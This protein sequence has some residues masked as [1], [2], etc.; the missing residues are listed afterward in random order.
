MPGEMHGSERFGL[1]VDS[2]GSVVGVEIERLRRNIRK[3]DAGAAIDRPCRRRRERQRRRH[4]VRARLEAQSEISK[5]QRR[6]AVA[7]GDRLFRAAISRKLG[8]ELADQRSLRDAR[9]A[10]CFRHGAD[11][12]GAQRLFSVRD[13]FHVTPTLLPFLTISKASLDATFIIRS[14]DDIKG[15]N[16]P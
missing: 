1:G 12:F 5:M 2:F 3:F 10:Q 6:R 9:R 7:D 4:Q 13:S 15:T 16:A 8:F 14:M 11:I